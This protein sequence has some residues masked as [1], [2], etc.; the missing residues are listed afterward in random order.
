[1]LSIALT[2]LLSLFAAAQP[3]DPPAPG[4]VFGRVVDATTGQPIAGA[5]VT[6]FGSA[7]VPIADATGRTLRRATPDDQCGRAVRR[8]RSAPRHPVPHGDEGRIHQ[9]HERSASSER[10]QSADPGSRRPARHRRRSAHV[11][12]VR[13]RRYRRRRGW[14][15]DRRR[16]RA[17]VR[18][19]VHRWPTA[20]RCR[21]D[22][23]D[24]RSRDLPSGGARAGRVQDLR[25]FE[26]GL[27]SNRFR[28]LTPSGI[29]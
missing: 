1:M 19:R 7:S 18:A 24:R 13:R 12:A 17:G 8:T 4:M 10:Q 15:A 27:G 25:Q 5:I 29:G 23:C 28:R 6:L 3:A 9:R 26:P 11:A 22:G 14:R 20:L 21:H 2:A 16:A